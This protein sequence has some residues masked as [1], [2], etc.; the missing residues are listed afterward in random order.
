MSRKRCMRMESLLPHHVVEQIL[1]SLAVNS[2]L[3]FKA[4]SKQWK[5]TI[6]SQFFQGKHLKHRLRRR[7]NRYHLRSF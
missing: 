5:S 4:V 1:E 3:R 2:L 7:R 6:E